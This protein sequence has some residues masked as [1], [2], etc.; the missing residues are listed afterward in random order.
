MLIERNTSSYNNR[1]YSRPWIA[2]VD[3][4]IDPKGVFNWGVWIGS[5]G[6]AGILQIEANPGD[7]I[8]SGQ[9]DFR[10]PR[11]SSP[12]WWQVGPSSELEPIETKAAAYLAYR[13]RPATV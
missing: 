9:K 7:I 5:Q 11:N 12:D 10:K 6:E 1:R 13:N 8:A 3:F 4:S 2:R